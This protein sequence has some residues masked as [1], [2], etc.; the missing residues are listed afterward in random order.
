MLPNI[1]SPEA[2]VCQQMIR[3]FLQQSTNNL[4]VA[5]DSCP[6]KRRSA[7]MV[8]SIDICLVFQK[9]FCHFLTTLRAGPVKG[10]PSLR[11]WRGW[12]G[13]V[14]KERFGSQS[15]IPGCSNMQCSSPVGRD[16]KVAA[17]S[18]G[19]LSSRY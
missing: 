18:F 6:E 7:P 19:S 2:D 12:I 4:L 8:A 14:F 13:P 10:S 17:T 16:S 1:N 15:E 5:L 9:K 11:I 3:V